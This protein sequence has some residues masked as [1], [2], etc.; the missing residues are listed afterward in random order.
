MNEILSS[1]AVHHPQ[2]SNPKK[3]VSQ[4]SCATTNMSEFVNFLGEIPLLNPH[5][6]QL[7][8]EI[9]T[10]R[11][12]PEIKVQSHTQIVFDGDRT[13]TRQKVQFPQLR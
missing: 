1:V 8:A 5:G 12:R 4:S 10:S 9:P 7:Q 3:N 6:A 2:L 11:R 13:G